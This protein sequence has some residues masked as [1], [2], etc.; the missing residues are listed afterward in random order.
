MDCNNS[1][2]VTT[3]K[4]KRGRPRKEKPEACFRCRCRTTPE[5]RKGWVDREG[6]S[7]HVPL[8]NACGLH[9]AKQR[10]SYQ[11]SKELN[12]IYRLLN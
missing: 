8:C 12:S 10:K 9:N 2:D 5:W 1:S 6:V 4:R 11:L 3:V 7:L